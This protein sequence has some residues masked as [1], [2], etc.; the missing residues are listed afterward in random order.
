MKRAL[1]LVALVACTESSS[2]KPPPGSE[3]RDR[4]A[5]TKVV[6]VDMRASAAMRDADEAAT[7]GDAGAALDIVAK[8]ATP[9]VDEGLGLVDKT[10]VDTPWGKQKRDALA[11][12]LRDRK[13]EMPR[14]E[15]AVKSGD[16]DKMLSAMQAQ[17][18][19]EKRAL[20]TVAELGP[21]R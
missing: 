5:L 15:D 14:Y 1:L 13:K 8:R 12:V 20:G 17:A 2:S 9:A 3:T 7:K 19:I 21:G 4:E 18:E 10:A 16:L 11:A 6:A